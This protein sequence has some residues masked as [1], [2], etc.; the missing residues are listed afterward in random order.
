MKNEN[1]K[2]SALHP[3]YAF[4]KSY[5][6]IYLRGNAGALQQI[7]VSTQSWAKNYLINLLAQ[8]DNKESRY[9]LKLLTKHEET[10]Q[11]AIFQS[12]TA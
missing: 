5:N 11:V 3:N 6:L 8:C 9:V 12:S 4:V 2:H 7:T 10:R 1:D